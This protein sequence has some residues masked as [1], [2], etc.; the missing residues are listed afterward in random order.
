MIDK[1]NFLELK[2]I[3]DLHAGQAITREHY[4]VTITYDAIEDAILSSEDTAEAILFI[5]KTY[6]PL[7]PF[8]KKIVQEKF[9][10]HLD[11]LEKLIVLI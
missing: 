6:A 2:L 10:G 5:L 7:T 3:S 11:R 4:V 1:D 9:P 8:L